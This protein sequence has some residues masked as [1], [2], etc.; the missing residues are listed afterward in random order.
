MVWSDE[1]K[2][3]HFGPNDH[4]FVWRQEGE[5]FNPENTIPTVKNGGGKIML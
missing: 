2:L 3:E 1:T 5:T 4:K